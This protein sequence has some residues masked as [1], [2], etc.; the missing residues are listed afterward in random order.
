MRFQLFVCVC[1][2]G[3]GWVQAGRQ[4]ELSHT[5]HLR[6]GEASHKRLTGSLRCRAT[7]DSVDRQMHS[8]LGSSDGGIIPTKLD[9]TP[10]AILV[11]PADTYALASLLAAMPCQQKRT[12]N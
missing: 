8:A 11:R 7:K 9:S 3:W 4:A 5:N 2:L 10:I 12:G 6:A 1:V